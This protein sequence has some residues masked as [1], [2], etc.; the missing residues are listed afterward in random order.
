MAPWDRSD[1]IAAD[2]S[3][4]LVSISPD[5][6]SQS[7]P[8]DPRFGPTPDLTVQGQVIPDSGRGVIGPRRGLWRVC[9]VM[10]SRDGGGVVNS[11]GADG[12]HL[13]IFCRLT[14]SVTNDEDMV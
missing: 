5:P 3:P 1:V 13:V 9:A 8:G 10:K 12:I 4:V 2:T 11:R 7:E 6:A 14:I